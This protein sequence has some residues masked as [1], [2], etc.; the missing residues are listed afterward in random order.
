MFPLLSLPGVKYPRY[1]GLNGSDPRTHDLAVYILQ[2]SITTI[3]HTYSHIWLFSFWMNW[4]QADICKVY[5]VH[6]TLYCVHTKNHK[7]GIS[8]DL[9]IYI[10]IVTLKITWHLLTLEKKHY[11]FAF[12]SENKPASIEATLVSKL[13]QP[14]SDLMTGVKCTA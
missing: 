11:Q 1:A 7:K 13:C 2:A 10:Q 5:S 6:C 14:S 8:D 9:S 4:V 3:L 12:L